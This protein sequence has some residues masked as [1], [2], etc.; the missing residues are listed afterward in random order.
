MLE[1]ARK[2][3]IDLE[4]IHKLAM[5]VDKLTPDNDG[6]GKMDQSKVVLSFLFKANE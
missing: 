3:V 1:D 5:N 4:L 2:G 6:A